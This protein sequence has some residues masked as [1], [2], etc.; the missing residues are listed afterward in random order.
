M[1]FKLYID[2]YFHLS[3]LKPALSPLP[4]YASSHRNR[5]GRR[6][7]V[8]QLQDSQFHSLR[9]HR[10]FHVPGLAPEAHMQRPSEN[11]PRSGKPNNSTPSILQKRNDQALPI[12]H[13]QWLLKTNHPRQIHT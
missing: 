9:E 3:Q 12:V 10:M 2:C 4:P 11:D 13:G 6:N 1:G 7:L 8:R 5:S